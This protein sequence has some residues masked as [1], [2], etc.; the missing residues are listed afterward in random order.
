MCQSKN[1]LLYVKATKSRVCDGKELHF[2]GDFMCEG[3]SDAEVYAEILGRHT[4]PSRQHLFP[5]GLRFI[6][7]EDTKL[8]CEWPPAMKLRGARLWI[9]LSCLQSTRLFLKTYASSWRRPDSSSHRAEQLSN[10][11][12]EFQQ[13]ICSLPK[14]LEHY[15]KGRVR[16]I[17]TG[18]GSWG[19]RLC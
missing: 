19:V 16:I 9:W 15:S 17:H 8:L 5:E 6:Q 12:D 14:Q 11:G 4:P 10:N 13:F 7:L 1:K 2:R 3:S 18:Y